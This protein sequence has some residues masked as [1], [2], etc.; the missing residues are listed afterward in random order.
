MRGINRH[1]LLLSRGMAD[2]L[3]FGQPQ[4][5]RRT[6]RWPDDCLVDDRLYL[7]T[8]LLVRFA[9]LYSL[10]LVFGSNVLP[11]GYAGP[12]RGNRRSTRLDS[13]A[14]A[15]AKGKVDCG[16]CLALDHWFF[17]SHVRLFRGGWSD[18]ES[19][20]LPEEKE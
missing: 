9:A 17:Y 11:R 13:A 16:W 10:G 3:G 1:G 12:P 8:W 2:G 6:D 5:N 15:M 4:Q 18:W 7:A 19:G 20:N 14:M